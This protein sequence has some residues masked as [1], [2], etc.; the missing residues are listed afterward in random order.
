MKKSKTNFKRLV[1]MSDRD[2]DFSEIPEITPKMFAKAIVRRG[3]NKV[4]PK[5]QITIR[6]DS[7][8]L[9]WFRK[10]GKG[11]QTKI[12]ELLRAYKEESENYHKAPGRS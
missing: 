1:A 6:V 10:T 3:L 2:I 7:S 12:G 5:K 4:E 8:V 11:Y 9:T